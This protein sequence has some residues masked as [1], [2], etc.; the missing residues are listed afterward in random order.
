MIQ[1]PAGL[2]LLLGLALSSSVPAI[3]ASAA[4]PRSD[5]DALMEKVIAHRDENWKK[6]VQ[7]VL[8]ERET[9]HLTGP[10]GSR[11]YGFER[12]YTWFIRQG[13]FIRSPLRADGVAIGESARRAFE[14]EWIVRERR[15]EQR[16]R[17]RAS[18]SAE[19]P[20]APAAPTAEPRAAADLDAVLSSGVEP[21]FV[22]A[23]Y[24]LRFTFEPGQYAL[25]GRERLFDRDVLRIEYYPRELFREGR[26]RPNRRLRDRDAEIEEKMNKV[27]LVTLWVDP[28]AH[29]ILQYTFDDIDMDFLPGRSL[30]RVDDVQAS[31][32]M[33]QPFPNVWLPSTIDIRFRMTLAVGSVDAR[34]HVQYHDYRLADVKVRVR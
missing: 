10:D 8:D 9:F 31:M 21:R 33:S 12:D 16:L 19:P 17:A 13:V 29:Q 24:F 34:Y 14:A 7:Y 6:L 2:V 18:N 23:A 22:S 26:A 28:A 1:R 4:A 3:T 32:R 11:V 5:L 20:P 27:S 25:V 30:A 15:R